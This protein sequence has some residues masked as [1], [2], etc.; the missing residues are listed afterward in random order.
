MS[1]FFGLTALGPNSVFQAASRG[2]P[3]LHLFD[4]ESDLKKAFL[5][6][7]TE[8]HRNN[9]VLPTK[10]IYRVLDIMY[11]G[12]APD[13]DLQILM[14]ELEGT[15]SVS[16]RALSAAFQRAVDKIEAESKLKD[17]EIG[18]NYFGSYHD[19]RDA[20]QRH[21][22]TRDGP[23]TVLERPLTVSQEYGWNINNN[24]HKPEI[25][26]KKSCPETIYAA[27]LIKSNVIY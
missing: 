23:Q 15:E 24:T 27:E 10:A 6:S 26:G 1:S 3:T 20:M 5:A 8:N 4:A 12:P 25:F 16:W 2:Q 13:T 22:R 14:K 17:D 18:S 21:K 9:D 7:T 19:Y 11:L